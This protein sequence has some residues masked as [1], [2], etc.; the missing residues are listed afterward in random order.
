VSKRP[1]L[2]QVTL[3]SSYKEEGTEHISFNRV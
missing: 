3:W 2:K 1:W